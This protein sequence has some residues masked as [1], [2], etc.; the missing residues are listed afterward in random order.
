M[1]KTVL[2]ITGM[3]CGHCEA[4]VNDAIRNAFDVKKVS[5]SHSKGE[6][7]IIS[8]NPPDEAKLRE[9][10]GKTGYTLEEISSAPYEKG[11][12]FSFLKK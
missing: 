11:G 3:M 10:I 7:E 1:T 8:E 2:K 4:H 5:S 6:T 12:L 9:V